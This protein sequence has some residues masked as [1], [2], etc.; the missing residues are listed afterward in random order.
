MTAAPVLRYYQKEALEAIEAKKK[1]GVRRQLVVLPTGGGKT[2]VFAQLP[3]IYGRTL[4]LA[5]REELLEQAKEKIEWA[6]P[7]LE[8]E[9]EQGSRHA[10]RADVVVASVPTLGRAGSGRIE[11]YPRGYFDVVVIDE[12]HHAAAPSYGRILDYF[13]S[14]LRIGVTAT[15]QRGD[16]TRLTDVF[17]EIVYFKSVGDM[18]SEGFLSP[19]TGIRIP[20]DVDISGVHTSHGDF[21]EKELSQAVNVEARNRLIVEAY[22]KFAPGRKAIVFCVDVAH[23]H[24]A[25]SAFTA[26]G[27]RCGVIT[28]AMSGDE[29]AETLGRFRSGGL[30]VL[31]NCMV[32]TEGF[33]EPS[34][35]CIILA[36]PTQSQ[37]LYTQIVGRG[38]R[39]NE[40]K[41]DCLIIDLADATKGKK[42]MGLPTLMGLPPDFDLE[43]QDLVEIGEKFKRLEALAPNEAARAKS[44]KDLDEAFERIDLFRP[45]PPNP[46]LLQYSNLIWMEVG[47]DSYYLSLGGDRRESIHISTNALGQWV[48]GLRGDEG[49]RVLGVVPEM[50]EAFVRSDRWVKKNRAEVMALVDANA[51]WR[52]AKVPPTEKQLRILR[53]HGVPITDDLTKGSASQ[54]ID[55]IFA[56]NPK[57]AKP[58]WLERKIE[59]QR[60]GP[61]F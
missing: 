9:I 38:T 6:N 44:V 26:S 33:D 2:V 43:N 59:A 29:R 28:G 60:R 18:I 15:P 45:P 22:R 58:A 53:K 13:D 24:D 40:G 46:E 1:D 11:K 49:E 51:A 27:L 50:T 35:D 21:S 54:I 41:Q 52:T 10:G 37:L 61:F 14:A 4:V 39:L 47:P 31:T 8:V 32:L 48:V 17:D 20:T 19:L 23:A 3:K 25:A 55:K 5:H 30:D 34:V 12:A 56:Q 7:G 36:R 42:P 57:K 16:K